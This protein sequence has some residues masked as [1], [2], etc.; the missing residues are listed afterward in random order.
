MVPDL[1]I[2]ASAFLFPG[3]RSEP[4]AKSTIYGIVKECGRLAGLKK[5]VSP[6]ILRHSFSTH[7][8]QKG[9]DINCLAQLLGHTNIEKTAIYTH[10]EDDQLT[11]AVLKLKE[12]GVV[13]RIRIK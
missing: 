6:H 12:D 2:S 5:R 11:E 4:L 10:T 7:L 8:H 1:S 9:V 13:W 3:R